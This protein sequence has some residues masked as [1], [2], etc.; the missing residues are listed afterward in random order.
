MDENVSV[1]SITLFLWGA[2]DDSD[3]YMFPVLNKNSPSYNRVATWKGNET[4][5]FFSSM[6][7][8]KTNLEWQQIQPREMMMKWVSEIHIR[9]RFALVHDETDLDQ[10]LNEK[11][12]WMLIGKWNFKNISE[13]FIM[14]L[15]NE[16][17]IT[18]KTFI[19]LSLFTVWHQTI[20]ACLSNLISFSD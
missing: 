4:T 8:I 18:L 20:V 11:Y 12:E 3:D 13:Y 14:T 10:G 9:F 6:E 5:L 7:C 16:R 2:H 17:Y 19:S 15:I 1:L